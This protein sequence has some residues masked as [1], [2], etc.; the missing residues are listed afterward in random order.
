[1]TFASIANPIAS[2]SIKLPTSTPA[3]AVHA[4]V[5]AEANVLKLIS[6][7]KRLSGLASVPAQ[8]DKLEKIANTLTNLAPAA[9]SE[10][11]EFLTRYYEDKKFLGNH[12]QQ[13]YGKTHG[14]INSLIT[15]PIQFDV[16]EHARYFRLE[17]E[18][19]RNLIT[20]TPVRTLPTAAVS[21][22]VQPVSKPEI[23]PRTDSES[24]GIATPVKPSVRTLISTPVTPAEK[25]LAKPSVLLRATTKPTQTFGNSDQYQVRTIPA[26]VAQIRSGG[27]AD[28]HAIRATSD[29]LKVQIRVYDRTTG[30]TE[31]FGDTHDRKIEVLYTGGHYQSYDSATHSG[32]ETMRRVGDCFY[33]A[34]THQLYKHRYTTARSTAGEIREQAAAHIEKQPA[35]YQPFLV[36]N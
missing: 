19:F 9:Q 13:N 24:R 18:A 5:T 21:P 10:V 29:A 2:A 34:V 17:T 16:D 35:D 22:V 33:D 3:S 27:W 11:K 7:L 32:T 26:L 20:V 6:E 31:I 30:R 8:L 1:M 4:S 12:L 15:R 25:P 36:V 23:Q 14:F 28:N